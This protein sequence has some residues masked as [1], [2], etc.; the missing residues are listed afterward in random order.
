MTMS[1]V[2]SYMR[3]D[4]D[5]L[6]VVFHQTPQPWHPQGIFLHEAA[7][8]VQIAKPEAYPAIYAQLFDAADA[9]F[10]DAETYDKS[11]AEI[12]QELAELAVACGV[13]LEAFLTVLMLD[14]TGGAKN[15]GNSATTALKLVTKHHRQRGIHV[16]PT[17]AVNGI[18]CDTS[19]GWTLPEWQAMIDPLV[20][21]AE[22][23]PEET[24]VTTPMV[25][26]LSRT[27]SF[28]GLVPTGEKEQV[29]ALFSEAM[30][31]AIGEHVTGVAAETECVVLKFAAQVVA[32]K[33]YFVKVELM[34]RSEVR[35]I[36]HVRIFVP[37]PHTGG[38]PE[39]HG[40]LRGKS[41]EEEVEFF[42]GFNC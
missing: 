22:P 7:L 18:V 1:V 33:N 4:P 32:G 16:T 17:C 25:G 20:G 14:T 36:V 40:L 29:E 39:L 19:S 5:A 23:E 3:R 34:R 37:L 9:R 31:N 38:T 2:P 28:G 6:K 35:D 30:K 26:G 12:Y 27:R 15:S 11:R 10:N 24:V 13:E 41:L 8:A 21:E 42:Q